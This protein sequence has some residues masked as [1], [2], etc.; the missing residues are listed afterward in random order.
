MSASA[1][2]ALRPG[3]L[4]EAEGSRARRGANL[5]LVLQVAA[6]LAVS[7]L[8]TRWIGAL[9]PQSLSEASGRTSYSYRADG[10]RGALELAGALGQRAETRRTSYG[11]LPPPESGVLVMIDP[12]STDEL[13]KTHEQVTDEGL[14]KGLGKWVA[15][16][17][18]LLATV[19]A[20][21]IQ[22]VSILGAKVELDSELG[23]PGLDDTVLA[24][25]FPDAP[26]TE[27]IQPEGVLGWDVI[28]GANERWSF[29]SPSTASAP[30]LSSSSEAPRFPFGEEAS[31][32]AKVQVFA[33]APAGWDVVARLD[34]HPFVLRMK[35]GQGEAW[36]VASAWPFTNLALARHETG[37]FVARLLEEVGEGGARALYFDEY[38][39]GLWERRGW[40]FW[41]H[42]DVLLYPALGLLF[43]ALLFLWRGSQR[44]GAPLAD[45]VPPRR[46]KEEFVVGIADIAQ[47]AGRHRAAAR[48]LLALYRSRLSAQGLGSEGEW[49]ALEERARASKTFGLDALRVLAREAD[50]L[51]RRDLARAGLE[52]STPEPVPAS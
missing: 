38:A 39:H 2:P 7:W 41:L 27:W 33:S 28:G 48:S 40:L 16:G 10:Y 11:Q 6:A 49:T 13:E 29:P 36:F 23:S 15:S 45:P 5:R 51:Y 32:P 14:A 20:R 12:L 42:K 50:R 3:E 31:A 24:K 21:D 35:Q 4:F 17:G 37:L 1:G 34:G 26:R 8:L 44:F 9:W 46:A 43:V 18:R 22:R 47:R 19:P 25:A 52:S 30:F